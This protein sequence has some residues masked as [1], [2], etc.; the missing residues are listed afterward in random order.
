M[1]SSTDTVAPLQRALAEIGE[2]DAQVKELNDKIDT[3]KERRNHLEGIAIEEMTNGRLDGVK[4]AGRSWRIEWSHS[5]SAP[6]ARKEAVMEAARSAGLLD[7]V[8]QV[9]TARLKALL[10]ERAKEAGTD[11][12]QPY[13]VGTEFDG[14]VGEFVRPVLRH[15]TSR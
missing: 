5:F 11:P 4:A 1:Q 7:A 15:V 6:E 9:N 3:L 12:R 14:L 8:T 10:A 13:S 2:I